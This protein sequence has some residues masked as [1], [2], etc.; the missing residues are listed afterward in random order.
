MEKIFKAKLF[1]LLLFVFSC[2]NDDYVVVEN[3]REFVEVKKAPSKQIATE[4]KNNTKNESTFVDALNSWIDQGKKSCLSIIEITTEINIILPKICSQSSQSLNLTDAVTK[5]ASDTVTGTKVKVE[6]TALSK[7]DAQ[8]AISR[9]DNTNQVRKL[10]R[11][12]SSPAILQTPK[13]PKITVE[14][15]RSKLEIVQKQ[16]EIFENAQ[17]AFQVNRVF[18]ISRN[19]SDIAEASLDNPAQMKHI[20][21]EI[22][23]STDRKTWNFDRFNEVKNTFI[24]QRQA[25]MNAKISID[26]AKDALKNNPSLSKS[27]SDGT[28]KDFESIAKDLSKK[29]DDLDQFMRTI[30]DRLLALQQI[31]QMR[32]LKYN[33][34]IRHL[35]AKGRM[36]EP[37]DELL[38][39][40][41]KKKLK[42][43]DIDDSR[44]GKPGDDDFVLNNEIA[45]DR[46]N[47]LS[48]KFDYVVI[49]RAVNPM[50]QTLQ[51]LGHPSKNLMAKIKSDEM[52]GFLP[53]DVRF[54]KIKSEEWAAYQIKAAETLTTWNKSD[55]LPFYGERIPTISKMDIDGKNTDMIYVGKANKEGTWVRELINKDDLAKK[56]QEGYSPY[57][58]LFDPM[59]LPGLQGPQREAIL[60]A[61]RKEKGGSYPPEG[62]DDWPLDRKKEFSQETINEFISFVQSKQPRSMQFTHPRSADDGI[63]DNFRSE[64]VAD[65]DILSF[66][67]K[68]LRD[69]DS[70]DVVLDGQL[71]ITNPSLTSMIDGGKALTTSSGPL[72]GIMRQQNHHAMEAFNVKYPQDMVDDFPMQVFLSRNGGQTF[73]IG[74]KVTTVDPKLEGAAKEAAERARAADIAY[75]LSQYRR[76]IDDMSEKGYHIPTNPNMVSKYGV[77]ED[78][79]NT[80]IQV[81]ASK[82]DQKFNPKPE[83]DYKPIHEPEIDA[84][85]IQQ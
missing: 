42:N 10:N 21:R 3:T 22:G 71:G 69:F 16:Y 32:L 53:T 55:L 74:R 40:F 75:S 49:N 44:W 61:W 34:M 60:N 4:S 72:D 15:V 24:T 23:I 82:V 63:L 31:G 19:V 37:E 56:I 78:L 5:A 46:Y 80:D 51:A 70:K 84:P 59:S 47:L 54:S 65:A 36:I 17:A 79:K 66:G 20:L 9:L 35:E 43:N 52:T 76:F 77:L 50:S 48:E 62:F 6:S 81:Q 45:L 29:I 11:S 85:V 25:L 27:F 12:N 83:A 30:N 68:D 58:V 28:L 33:D 26:S 67:S 8:N 39:G 13:K 57:K 7:T 18:G 14:E 73:Y 2:N 41:L 38:L 1:I 64:V